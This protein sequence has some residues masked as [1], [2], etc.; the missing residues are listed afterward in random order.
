MR[1]FYIDGVA[2]STYG[3]FCSGTGVFNAPERDIQ[4]I[5][6]PGRN[7]ELTIDNGRYR[8][9]TVS[10]PA[11]FVAGF[12]SNIENARA[13]LCKAAGYRKLT[14]DWNTTTYRM[15]RYT[16][17]LDL[18][19]ATM[20][21]AARATLQFDCM[22]QRFLNSGDTA[23]AVTNGGTITNPTQF[24]AEPLITVNGSGNGTLTVGSTVLT[25]SSIS[26]SVNLDC[27][28]KRAYKG[29]TALDSNVSGT[30]PVL[31][32]GSNTVSWTGG[33]TGV[34]IK[35]RWWTL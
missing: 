18:D 21:D 8:N 11:I 31:V 33:I 19:V 25:I 1:K 6:I 5:E 2:S 7:G 9:I 14:D 32:S 10:Y 20:L 13:W 17:G 28:T 3:I 12:Q 34:S 30:Y 22:P 35:P 26:V 27:A 16:G 29:T 23:V 4:R 15:A 24:D